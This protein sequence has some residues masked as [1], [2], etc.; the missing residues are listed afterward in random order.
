MNALQFPKR[1]CYLIISHY[2]LDINPLFVILDTTL[3]G[4]SRGCRLGEHLG[5]TS[6]GVFCF[7]ALLPR[8]HKEDHPSPVRFWV[9]LRFSARAEGEWAFMPTFQCSLCSALQ[10]RVYRPNNSK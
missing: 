1:E 9:V 3:E 4:A 6:I 5:L 8:F 7:M 2:Y 10:R